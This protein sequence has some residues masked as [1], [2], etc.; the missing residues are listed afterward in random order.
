MD[1]ANGFK[2]AICHD[3]I[4]CD[5]T[6][7]QSIN[8]TCGHAFGKSCM[9]KWVESSD[10][11][12]CL[13]C[14]NPLT[15]IEINE[16]KTIPLQERAVIILEKAFKVFGQTISRLVSPFVNSTAREFATVVTVATATATATAAVAT[17]V[18]VAT[19][20]DGLIDVSSIAGIIAGITAWFV[21][22]GVAVATSLTIVGAAAGALGVAVGVDRANA[23]AVGATA[24][25]LGTAGTVFSYF[26]VTAIAVGSATR[27]VEITTAAE[28]LRFTATAGA[29]GVTA[30][31]LGV[32]A[33]A[34]GYYNTGAFEVVAGALGAGITA[35]AFGAFGAFG[36][37]VI[38]AGA[39]GASGASAA[40]LVATG[41]IL[42][43]LGAG[44]SIIGAAVGADAVDIAYDEQEMNPVIV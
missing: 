18:I 10:Q 21:G 7:Y 5:S 22:G 29:I 44:L 39:S 32:T 34:V 17:G 25:A 40:I 8:L 38:P 43:A 9:R 12:N 1:S 2:C 13:L 27:V 31:A 30:G 11:K 41:Y 4:C 37:A 3:S 15:D 33:G 36:A 24:G 14:R 16:I 23:G 28:A 42:G 26:G 35:G 20:V 6:K 19:D